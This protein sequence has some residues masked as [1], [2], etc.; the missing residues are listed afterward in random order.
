MRYV[1]NKHNHHFNQL[2]LQTEGDTLSVSNLELYISRSIP[3]SFYIRV[4]K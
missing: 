3:F 1:C 4:Q 2:F